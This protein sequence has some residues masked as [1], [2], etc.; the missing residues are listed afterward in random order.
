MSLLKRLIPSLEKKFTPVSDINWTRIETLIHGPGASDRYE[1]GGDANSAVFACLMTI[2]TAYTEPPPRLVRVDSEGKQ[3][4]IQDSPLMGLLNKPTPNGELSLDEL[5]F[6]TAWAKHTDGN[7]YW[8]KVRSG[9]PLSGNVIQ[10]WPVSPALMRPVTDTDNRGRAQDWISRY[11]MQVAANEWEPVPLENVIHFRLGIDPQDMRRGLSPLKRLLR[12]I[13]SDE[14]AD[15]FTQTLLKNYAIPGL[16]VIPGQGEDVSK[17]DADRITAAMT[18]KFGGDNRGKTAVLS[19]H[20]DIKQFG[21]SPKDLEMNTIHRIPEE[22]I[23]AVIGVPA[24][25]AG[26]GAGLERGTFSN[27]RELRELFAEQKLVPE[28]RANAARLNVS[29]KPDFTSD[30]AVMLEFD[31]SDVRALQEDEHKKYERLNLGLTGSRQ[32]ITVNEARADVG[33][34]PV[35]GGDELQNAINLEL[36]TVTPADEEAAAKAAI[37]V[38]ETKQTDRRREALANGRRLLRGEVAGRMAALLDN[39]FT[40]L[41]ADLITALAREEPAVTRRG[42]G[43]VTAVKELTQRDWDKVLRQ[44]FSQRRGELKTLVEDHVIEIIQLTWP[45]LNLE[46]QSVAQFNRNDPAVLAALREA[47]KHINGIVDT[48]RTAV[49]RYLRDAYDEGLPVEE[50]AK[51]VRELVAETYQGR[52][53][54]I[55]RTEVGTAQNIATHGRYKAAGVKHVQV[56]DNGFENSHEFCRRVAGKVVTLA[57]SQRNPLQHPNCVRAFG[58]VF[59]YEGEVFGEEEPWS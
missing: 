42:N 24:I 10:L 55:A 25:L 35:E 51:R 6:W 58:A 2:S 18:E 44:L 27:A 56:F 20:G 28:W 17:A 26:L 48:T 12:Q 11:E 46:L 9:N 50:M 19:R 22:R 36:P 16:V 54:A 15:K 41:A 49:F 52:G 37:K 3:E 5:M 45:Y 38:T 13:A 7:A 23:A 53:L 30:P 47:G 33:L 21:F 4:T 40:D 39:W 1:S 32:W 59:D 14:E 43:K 29:L 34:P 57:W 8:L 31:I